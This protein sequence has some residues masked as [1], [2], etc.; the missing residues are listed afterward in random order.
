[1]NIGPDQS[2]VRAGTDAGRPA[3]L[4]S[5]QIAFGR[6]DDRRVV[7]IDNK[8]AVAVPGLYH[9]DIIVRT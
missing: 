7:I 3:Q 2:I 6:F 4:T 5:T 9:T 8:S 1:M